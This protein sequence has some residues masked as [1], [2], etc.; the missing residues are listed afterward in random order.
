[1]KRLPRRDLKKLI[2]SLSILHSDI[3]PANLSERCMAALNNLISAEITAFD[4]FTDKGVHTGKH[5]YDPP[6]AISEAEFEIFAHVVHEH[7]FFPDV[8][9]NK[10]FDAMTTNDFLTNQKF[11]RTAIYN[12]FYRIYSIDRQMLIAFSD[13]PDSIITCAFNRTKSDFSDEERMLFNMI[14]RHLQ[15]SVQ[16]SYKIE[17]Y[18]K[19]ETLLNSALETRSSGVIV[20]NSNKQINYESNFARRMLEKYFAEEKAEFCEL[21]DSLERWL[22]DESGKF[23]N[24]N[25]SPP[26]QVLKIEKKNEKLEICLLYSAET[27]EITL[28][29]EEHLVASPQIFERLNLTKRESEILFW[30]SFGKTNKDIAFL[31][32]IS[33][34]TVNKHLEHIFIKLGVETRTAAVSIALDKLNLLH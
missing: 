17:Q 13:K 18:N 3:D 31:L 8:F 11:Y 6:E 27:Q 23:D 22:E 15:M 2:S 25:F 32:G 24:F 1:M 10:R 30:I 33:P 21:P 9:G 7:P 14:T 29:L 19:T 12:E 28:L 16:N 34:R 20:L 5:W 4:F 26:P